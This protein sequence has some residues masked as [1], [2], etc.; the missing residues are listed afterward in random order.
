MLEYDLDRCSNCGGRG[1]TLFP[2]TAPREY[3]EIT[4]K[5]INGTYAKVSGK[6][7]CNVCEGDGYIIYPALEVVRPT[8]RTEDE[9]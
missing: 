6:I 2:I 4:C 9:Q 1:S 5:R 7:V 3:I 8:V